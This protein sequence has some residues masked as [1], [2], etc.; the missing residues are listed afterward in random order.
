[1]CVV[2]TTSASPYAPL[3]VCLSLHFCHSLSAYHCLCHDNRLERV[4]NGTVYGMSITM[5][6]IHCR[7][8]SDDTLNCTLSLSKMS[9]ATHPKGNFIC[10]L[11]GQSLGEKL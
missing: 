8:N 2:G 1:M 7:A 3:S 10:Y 5:F 11:V 9:E 4:A 6:D